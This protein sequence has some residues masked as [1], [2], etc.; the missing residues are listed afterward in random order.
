MIATHLNESTLS[1][2]H[3]DASSLRVMPL[4]MK[5][6][7]R[8]A[9]VVVALS[10]L[11]SP[12]LAYEDQLGVTA[13]LGYTGVFG[14]TSLPP[15]GATV[16]VGVSYGLGDTWEI[17]GRLDYALLFTSA[18]RGALTADLVYLIDVLSFVP[19]VGLSVGGAITNV[20]ANALMTSQL[21]GDLLIGAV[22]GGDVMLGRE[23]TI[24]FEVRPYVMPLHFASEPFDLAALLRVQRLIEL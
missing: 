1:P 13:T 3:H 17:R 9:A 23:W 12:A 7:L 4:S 18:H 2:E 14:D 8:N 21:R 19:Y 15:H 20:D 16:G 22:V 5:A 11:T 6:L 24:G 10:A